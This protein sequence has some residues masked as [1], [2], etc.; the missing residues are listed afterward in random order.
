MEHIHMHCFSFVALVVLWPPRVR[1]HWHSCADCFG[2][3]RIP[4][5]ENDGGRRAKID[6]ERE[7]RKGRQG[8]RRRQQEVREKRERGEKREGT[9]K[10]RSSGEL[11]KLRS[12][13]SCPIILAYLL[14]AELDTRGVVLCGRW[15]IHCPELV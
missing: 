7:R 2:G 1:Q 13:A 14:Q 8:G 12:I 10:G 6:C 9:A 15:S 11:N 5:V 4:R 3:S